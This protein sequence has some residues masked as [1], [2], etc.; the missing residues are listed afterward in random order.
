M[1]NKITLEQVLNEC[2]ERMLVRGEDMEGCLKDYPALAEELRPLL[3][4][5]RITRT[6]ARIEPKPDAHARNR[7]EFQQAVHAASVKQQPKRWVMFRPV[8]S[9]VAAVLLVFVM[10]SGFTVSA[11]SNALPDDSLYGV[12]TATENVRMAFTFTDEAKA[13]YNA[14]LADFRVEEIVALASTG[15]VAAIESTTERLNDNLNQIVLLTRVPMTAATEMNTADGVYG[16]LAAPAIGDASI[17]TADAPALIPSVP[18]PQTAV[19]QSSGNITSTTTIALTKPAQIQ[20]ATA[21]PPATPIT[22]PNIAPSVK[23]PAPDR[24]SSGGSK[25]SVNAP[26]TAGS[27]DTK[28]TAPNKSANSL[29]TTV[30][31]STDKNLARLYAALASAPDS[32]KPAI[33]HAIDVAT[34]GYAAANTAANSS[35]R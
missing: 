29:Q 20:T 35:K 26:A 12:K 34:A 22:P 19:A 32:A 18:V 31:N 21:M 24:T 10:G 23:T 17:G 8:W 27:G 1:D 25:P 4:C 3:D 33:Q 13:E 11:A 5:A 14:E 28:I 30:V 6:S 7:Y 16:I 2:L 15:N 9:S